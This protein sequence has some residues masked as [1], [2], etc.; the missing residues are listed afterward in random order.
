M[1][2]EFAKPLA[3]VPR[4]RAVPTSVSGFAASGENPRST[5]IS[6]AMTMAL[7]A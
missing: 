7:T 2:A 6:A 3:A 1:S 4:P 5:A